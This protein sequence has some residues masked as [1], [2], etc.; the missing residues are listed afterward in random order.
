MDCKTNYAELKRV[1]TYAREKG[2]SVQ[3][4]YK[5]IEQGEIKSKKIDGMC[6][7]VKE[8]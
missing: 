6:F 2:I 5:Q 3:T 4:V 7:I 8:K 1:S